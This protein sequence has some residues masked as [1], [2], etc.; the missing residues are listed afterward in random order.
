MEGDAANNIPESEKSIR[1]KFVEKLTMN[2]S[3]MLTKYT[4]GKE[5][6]DTRKGL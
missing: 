5:W 1:Y 3:T 2:V 6:K 4:F